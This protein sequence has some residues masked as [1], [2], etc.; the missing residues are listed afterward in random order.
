[1]VEPAEKCRGRYQT[2]CPDKQ[3]RDGGPDERLA[4]ARMC[5]GQNMTIGEL[6]SD[7]L[8]H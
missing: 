1:M 4:H 8:P 3:I 6:Y 7:L 2:G 5:C